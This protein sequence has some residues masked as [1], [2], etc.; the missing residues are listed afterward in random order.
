MAEADAKHWK[1]GIAPLSGKIDDEGMIWGRGALDM[2]GMGVIE[3]QTLIW[4]KRLQVPLKR[5]VILLAVADEED[6]NRGMQHVVQRHWDKIGCSHLI[7]EGGIGLKDGLFA[8]QTVFP[9]TVAE[10]GVLWVRMHV[11][12]EAG[13]GSTPLPGQTPEKLLAA[14]ERVR[15]LK[16]TPRV[17]DSLVEL[18][19][20]VGR[21]RGGL[22]GFVMQRPAL[23][24][25]VV[26]RQLMSK[27]TTR[28]A[29]TDTC[30]L[31]GLSTGGN[32]PNVIPSSASA[33]FDCR[34]LPGTTPAEM[35]RRLHAAVGWDPAVT[36][37]QLTAAGAL[38]SPW[39]DPLFEALRRNLIA[40]RDDAAAGPALSVGFTDSLYARQRGVRA[41]GMVPFEVTLDEVK[42]MHAPNERVSSD[43]VRRGLRILFST[44]VEVSAAAGGA[45]PGRPRKPPAFKPVGDAERR[46]VPG[47]AS[48]PAR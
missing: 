2:K 10:K 8:G 27:P 38:T 39:D 3:L 1:P 5:D 4:L 7:N 41:Y 40:G 15:K 20:R 43:N 24:H 6:K 37:E 16:P 33:T 34:L 48:A 36:F 25:S 30:N 18:L 17:H 23:V 44:V 47:P 29:I 19:A 22:T 45:A 46:A 42:T 35:I 21:Q 14:V 31:T 12:G 28:A 26:V 13:H 9:I 11:K 32:Q